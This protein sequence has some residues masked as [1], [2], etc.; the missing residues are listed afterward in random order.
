MQQTSFKVMAD[1]VMVETL[2]GKHRVW[3]QPCFT[4]AV[5]KI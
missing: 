4:E 5:E 3:H 2:V 1:K